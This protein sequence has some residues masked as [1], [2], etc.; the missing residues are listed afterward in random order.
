MILAS[1]A[2][3]Q[4][5]LL[6]LMVPWEERMEEAQE[7]KREKYGGGFS[8]ERVEDQVYASGGGQ[9][10]ICQPF[11]EQSLRHTG[12]NRCKPKKSHR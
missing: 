8:E 11:P 6:E 9:S 7:R 3:K 2:T 12:H 4:L 1:E 10:G 5:F